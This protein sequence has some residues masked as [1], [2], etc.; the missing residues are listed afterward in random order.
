MTIDL[1]IKTPDARLYLFC[2]VLDGWQRVAAKSGVLGE[3]KYVGSHRLP[4]LLWGALRALRKYGAICDVEVSFDDYRSIGGLDFFRFRT[5]NQLLKQA[6]ERKYIRLDELGMTHSVTEKGRWAL[7]EEG[8]SSI[9]L[10]WP[11]YATEGEPVWQKRP[12]G[13]PEIIDVVDRACA[14]LYL[15]EP[16]ELRLYLIEDAISLA[17]EPIW[18]SSVSLHSIYWDVATISHRCQVQTAPRF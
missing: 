1:R 6:V 15:A 13:S 14:P 10:L 12:I 9:S 3:P 2:H 16:E 5:A 8:A 7:L 18:Q 4:A 11:E 17:A